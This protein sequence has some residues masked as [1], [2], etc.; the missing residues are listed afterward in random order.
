MPYSAAQMFEVVN[1]VAAY[2]EFLPWCAGSEI[3]SQ[4]KE[5]MVAKLLMAKA[6]F[7][8]SFTTRNRLDHPGSIVVELVDGPFSKLLGSW[9]F[10][11]LGQDG[12]RISMDLEFDFNNRLFN[13][14]LAGVFA[15]AADKMVDAFCAR[16]NELY[17]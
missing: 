16:A 10:D 13:V 8:Q 14:T 4:D 5:W 17:G 15:L 7:T 2:P 9:R 1:D 11:Q 3:L 12:C 6:G